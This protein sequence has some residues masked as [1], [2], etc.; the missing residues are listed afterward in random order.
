[1]FSQNY[2]SSLQCLDQHVKIVFM[3][4]DRLKDG[5]IPQSF[6]RKENMEIDLLNKYFNFFSHILTELCLFTAVFGSTYQ[7][8]FYAC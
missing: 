2:A 7:N 5:L 4:V 8:C 1:M 6:H 3:H